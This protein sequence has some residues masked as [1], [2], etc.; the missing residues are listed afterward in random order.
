MGDV[1]KEGRTVLFVSHNM[2]AVR[3][4]CDSAVLLS[5][6]RIQFGGSPDETIS[7]Y[8]HALVPVG[9]APKGDMLPRGQPRY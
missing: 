5:K 2:A 6:G 4:L 9:T 1:A 7:E 8:L 3:N